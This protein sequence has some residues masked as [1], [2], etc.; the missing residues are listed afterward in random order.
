M[1][2]VVAGGTALSPAATLV[3]ALAAPAAFDRRTHGN[4]TT[5]AL[6]LA[7]QHTG[8]AWSSP[9]PTFASGEVRTQWA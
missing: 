8:R 7:E 2:N 3:I 5:A 9:P 1:R 6:H 4:A